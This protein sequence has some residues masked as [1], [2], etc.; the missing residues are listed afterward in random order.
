MFERPAFKHHLHVAAIQPDSLVLL[1]ESSH[2]LLMGPV[3]AELG[4]LLDG[5][6]TVGDLVMA[7]QSVASPGDILYALNQLAARGFLIEGLGEA[8][9][10]AS[11]FWH[12]F[13]AEA[14][15]A[16][17]RLAAARVGLRA[18]GPGAQ[19]LRE[20]LT[21]LAVRVEES[22][23][24]T[25]VVTDDYLNPAL[26]EV[27]AQQLA[28]RQPW[29][30]VKL[31]GSVLWLGPWFQPPDS[32][33]WACLAQRLRD[34]R[35]VEAYIQAKLGRATYFPTSRG[36][37][38]VT[39]ALGANWAATQIARWIAQGQNLPL[40]NRLL[41]WDITT[42][43]TAQHEL[44]R[45]PQCPACGSPVVA[46]TAQPVTL[47][48]VQKKLNNDGGSRSLFP[49]EV[50]ARY[51]HHVSPI[52]GVV[53]E[54]VDQSPDIDGL[55]YSYAAGHNFAIARGDFEDLRSNLRGRSGGKGMTDTQA[56]VSAIAEA[57]ERYSGVFRSDGEVLRRA[58]YRQLGTD[59]VHL[60]DCLLFSERQY[61]E[62]NEWNPHQR[63]R[64]HLVPKPFDEDVELDWTPVWSL[65]HQT[66]RYVP[67]VYCYYGHPD[68][69]WFFCGSDANGCAAGHTREEA[70]LQ[71][72]LELVER[73]AVALWWYNR[74]RRPS[75]DLDSFNL[76]Y[77][78]EL[79]AHYAARQRT[80]WLLDLTSD[81]GIPVFGA[82]SS[83]TDRPVEDIL[84]G[85]GAHLDPRIAALRALTELNQFFPVAMRTAPDGSTVY[86]TDEPDTLSWLQQAT[87]AGH[88]Y[89]KPDESVPPRLA[90]DFDQ[91]QGGDLL[92]DIQRCQAAVEQAGLEVLVLDQTR[93][94]VGMP[95]CRV[96]IPGLRHFWRRL[97]P[98]RLYTVPVQLGWR[99]EPLAEAD[100]NPVSVFF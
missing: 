49:E 68:L 95:V 11:A 1:T 40:H 70:V 76:P 39:L 26:E 31:V 50:F 15:V 35:Q 53:T 65:T 66:F 83:R 10:P 36:A 27:N 72:V 3:L 5:H 52:S 91:P 84:I 48:H 75:V 69:K 4:P 18:L 38:P 98:G 63:S 90:G 71:G 57:I 88:P 78:Q 45:R 29:L 7:L 96:I 55:T 13:G 23:D 85:F 34:N 82:L 93:A 33:C 79:R 97:G 62:R 17:A 6:H 2:A 59:A 94:D 22:G 20:A 58:S 54:L 80:L 19:A 43:A 30:L 60:H 46:P 67:T 16:R 9:T 64:Y 32:A 87:L 89:L 99:A 81:L 41:T 74:V 8:A 56:K 28:A 25:I 12:S 42:T 86:L 77:I 24:V 14:P 73:D 61:Q 92:D 51:Q 47:G 21:S 100:L 44:V 37:L